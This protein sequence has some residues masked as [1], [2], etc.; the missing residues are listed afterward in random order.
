MSD[1]AGTLPLDD[2]ANEIAAELLGQNPMMQ[3]L[4]VH[5]IKKA[6]GG[7]KLYKPRVTVVL[8][9]DEE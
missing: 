4:F 1:S 9:P 5:A 3:G 6:K 7:E 8:V 2:E